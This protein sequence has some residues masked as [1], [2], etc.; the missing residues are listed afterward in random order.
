MLVRFVVGQR[1]ENGE[2]MKHLTTRGLYQ[3]WNTVRGGRIAP[4]RYEIEPSQIVPFLSETV[5][6]EEPLDSC[7][8]RVA[9]TRVCELL[10][11]DLRGHCFFDLWGT[12]DQT[13]LRDNMR[14]IAHYGGVGL[15]TFKG[16]LSDD[17]PPAEL[18]LLLLPLTHGRERVERV[19]GSITTLVEPDWLSTTLPTQL[20]LTSNEMIW[21][22]GRPRAVSQPASVAPQTPGDEV[23]VISVQPGFRRARLVRHER[24]SF[25]VYDGGRADRARHDSD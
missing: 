23:P 2:R 22:D 13:I 1:V 3:Y 15:F 4:R 14:T 12:Q 10:G 24:R 18:E 5:I 11:D 20:R 17:A 25:L 8:I 21:P 16:E 6:L 9:G 19:L 7:R